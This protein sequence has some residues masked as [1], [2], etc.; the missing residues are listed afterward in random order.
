MLFNKSPNEVR[1]SVKYL[2]AQ[3]FHGDT[4]PTVTQPC[5]EATGVSTYSPPAR[6]EICD[7]RQIM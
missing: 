6:Y 4:M 1:E 3:V 5:E 7:S 2:V